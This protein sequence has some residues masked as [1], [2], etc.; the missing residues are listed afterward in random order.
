MNLITII[1]KFK[2]LSNHEIVKKELLNLV[3]PTRIEKGCVDY[4]FYQDNE[5]PNVLM[6]YENWETNED[7][8]AHMNTDRFKGTFAKIDGM[9]ELEVSKLTKIGK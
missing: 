2:I 5:D 7:L 3:D 1:A 4:I 8:E 6:L 9:Y